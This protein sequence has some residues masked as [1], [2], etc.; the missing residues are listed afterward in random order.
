MKRTDRQDRVGS[1][2]DRLQ[3]RNYQ[4]RYNAI[5]RE[6]DKMRIARLAKEYVANYK[7][8]M[9]GSYTT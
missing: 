9:A 2:I 4:K 3:R 7:H 1:Y 8:L 6:T 5:D